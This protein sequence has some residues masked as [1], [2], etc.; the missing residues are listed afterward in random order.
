[1]V[2]HITRP[3]SLFKKKKKKKKK[4]RKTKYLRRWMIDRT[5]KSTFTSGKSSS[6]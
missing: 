3:K 1:M 4:K 6:C 5:W 2:S